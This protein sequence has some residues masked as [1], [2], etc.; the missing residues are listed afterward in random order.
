MSLTRRP[1]RGHVDGVVSLCT[2]DEHSVIVS[3]SD[4][5]TARLWDLRERFAATRL[6]KLPSSRDPSSVQ[7]INRSVIV[8]SGNQLLEFDLRKSNGVI[9]SEHCSLFAAP[10]GEDINDFSLTRS[11]VLL[12]DDSGCLRRVSMTTFQEEC[13]A[14][15]HSNIASVCRFLPSGNQFISGG[16]D[17]KFA[18]GRVSENLIDAVKTFAIQSLIPMDEDSQQPGQTINPPFVTSLEISPNQEQVVI[19]SGDGSVLVFDLKKGGSKLETRRPAWGGASVHPVSV[20]SLCW[21]G[22]SSSVWSCGND[23]VLNRMDEVSISVRYFLGFKPNSVIELGPGKVAVA[24]TQ[25]D[26]EIL[27]FR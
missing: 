21:S 24:G 14:Q 23:S 27:D 10:D 9:V 8:S 19:G 7:Y 13:S 5:Y 4:D 20:S 3:A 6:I 16:Y 17:C 25:N 11:A 1:L 2:T 12:P 22:D 15:V 26:I 18:I